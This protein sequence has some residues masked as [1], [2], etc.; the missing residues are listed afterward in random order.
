MSLDSVLFLIGFIA[1]LILYYL[2]RSKTGRKGLL[3]AASA[4]FIAYADIDFLIIAM[5]FAFINFTLGKS[6]STSVSEKK[7]R[8]IYITGIVL[9]ILGLAL[10]KYVD[11]ISLNLNEFLFDGRATLPYLN[12]ILPLGIS[13]YT[14]QSIG[15]LFDVYHENDDV[16]E[17]F[18]DFSVFL[19]FFPKFAGGPIE[20]GYNFLP[21]LKDSEA[22]LFETS[23]FKSGLRLFT[24]GLFK[25]VVV[26]TAL[27]KL[28]GPAYADIGSFHGISL[29]MVAFIY[30]FQIYAEFSGYTDM[31]LGA[32]RMMGLKLSP[33]F[34]APFTATSISD[35][36]RR[37]HI[38]LSTWVSD[39]I[40]TPL[41]MK[42]AL[43]KDWGKMGI[44]IALSS[45]FL[46]LGIWHGAQWTYIAFGVIQALFISYEIMTRKQRGSWKKKSN[47]QF[48]ER[49]SNIITVSL[50]ALSCIF[51]G[52]KTMSDGF[53]FFQQMFSGI[54]E[55]VLAAIKNEE[56][57]RQH[58]MYMGMDSSVLLK[59]LVL[60]GLFIWIQRWIDNKGMDTL[61]DEQST[62]TRWAS[63]YTIVAMIFFNSNEAVS[64][65]YGTF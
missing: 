25:K 41:S 1:F 40:F 47:P 12:V 60:F 18:L 8:I 24:W 26:S 64:F 16:E 38:S 29:I 49:S 33:N 22:Q 31:A 45:S 62:L 54:G 13:Y 20:R 39:Y 10:F 23:N 50:Y 59:A 42:I 4:L 32:A 6:M 2:I 36:W 37:W 3:L 5:L 61:L 43:A 58:I 51:F 30:P 27:W 57:A 28:I 46:I 53:L 15:Y 55:S 14:F 56:L 9:N 21:Q 35:F 7:K 65:L 44:I 52:V 19:L 11:F 63:Y 34:N 48:Y 17:S